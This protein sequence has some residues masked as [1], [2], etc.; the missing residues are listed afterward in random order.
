MTATVCDA[1]WSESYEILFKDGIF[2]CSEERELT[3]SCEWDANGEMGR[4]RSDDHT[5]ET[6]FQAAGN[7]NLV[8][9]EGADN[10]RAAG[11][12]GAFAVCKAS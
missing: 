7:F 1:M 2:G 10:A 6:A 5:D 4:Y 8:G 12:I 3:I 9:E 11:Y